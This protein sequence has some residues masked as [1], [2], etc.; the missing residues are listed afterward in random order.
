MSI[1]RTQKWG[2]VCL[3]GVGLFAGIAAIMKLL[4]YVERY[5]ATDTTDLVTLWYRGVIWAFTE[6]GLSLFAA[7]ILALRPLARYISQG[8]AS[9][10]STFYGS[11]NSKKLSDRATQSGASD[12][13]H[14]SHAKTYEAAEMH[15][16]GVRNDVTVYTEDNVE[17]HIQHPLYVAEAYNGSHE[18][19]KRLVDG[20]RR[21]T[22]DGDEVV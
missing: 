7:S 20:K 5:H 16:I 1:R 15:T 14:Q 18:S 8:W 2:I 11:G 9:F 12:G 4:V 17:N 3:F 10:S 6:H 19:Q 22:K 21:P 13:S